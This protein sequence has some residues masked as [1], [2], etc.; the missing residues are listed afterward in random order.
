M[1]AHSICLFAHYDPS[2]RVA[3]YVILYVACLAECG[4]TVH[5]ACSGM[6]RTRTGRC[7]G[8]AACRGVFGA[9]ARERRTRFRRV[10]ASATAGLRAGRRRSPARQRQRI[11]PVPDLRPVFAAMRERALRRLGH[12][13]ERPRA[14]GICILVRLP[15]RRGARP[16]RRA[17]RV[18][19]TVRGDG[20]ARDRAAWRAWPRRRVASGETSPAGACSRSRA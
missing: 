13:G 12:G 5:L 11:R 14:S 20:Q 18:R 6:V 3:P 19:P 10:A 15:L 8:P 1:G 7:G 2:G 17:A 9:C 16:A 4:W